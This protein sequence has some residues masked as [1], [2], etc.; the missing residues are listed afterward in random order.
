MESIPS[1]AQAEKKEQAEPRKE[2][3]DAVEN[4]G[5]EPSYNGIPYSDIIE[6][7]FEM[8]NG[9]KH[10]TVGDR[11]VKTFELAVTLRSICDYDQ[12]KLEAVPPAASELSTV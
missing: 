4:S 8:Y 10:P 6:K 11:N 5:E 3:S 2:A 12:A 1:V 9:G 7:Y